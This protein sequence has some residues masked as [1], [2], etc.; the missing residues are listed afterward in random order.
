MTYDAREKSAYSGEP[1]EVYKFSREGL[2]SWYYTSADADVTV[3]GQLYEA[4][5]IKRNSVEASQDV[6]RAAL[7]ITMSASED[8]PQQFIASPPTD[9]ISIEVRRYHHTDAEIAFL[10]V[11][12]VINVEHMEREAVVTCESSV[13]S[14]KR[15][16]LRRVYQGSCPHVLYGAECGLDKAAF[17]VAAVLEAGTGGVTL[18]SATFDGYADGYFSGG[19][20]TVLVES[21]VNRAFVTNHV[22]PNL[23]TNLPL[24]GG[25]VGA[26]VTAYP[27]CDHSLNTCNTK[28]SNVLNY[29]GFPFTPGDGKNPM[30]GTSIF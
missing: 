26:A 18:V 24:Q 21:C 20:V 22:G 15:P 10:W 3:L 11:G 29:G 14:L 5:P 17:A 23:T 6:K 1:I 8:F 27:G 4:V 13:S 2:K 16:T 25:T 7:R 12:R 30:N 19:F 28:F 9:R